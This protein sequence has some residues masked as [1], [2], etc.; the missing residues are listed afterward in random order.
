MIIQDRTGKG[1]LK[2]RGSEN[3]R[4]VLSI[5]GTHLFSNHW[6]RAIRLAR[7]L[8][9]QK[10]R[11]KPFTMC[12]ALLLVLLLVSPSAARQPATPVVPAAQSDNAV[13][14]PG[15]RPGDP[16]D[17]SGYIQVPYSTALNPS[18]GQITIE[19]WVKRSASDRNETIVGNGWQT[20]YWLGF[21][22]AGRLRFIPHGS[23]SIMDGN[24]VVQSDIWTHV[25]VTYD[26]TTRYY[27]INGVLDK[28][29][30]S[31]SGDLTPAPTGR[32]LGIGFDVDDTFTPN[33]FGGLIDNL[34]IWNVVRNA[35]AISDSMF[36]SFGTSQPGLLAEWSFDGDA[37]DPV[38]DHD[39]NLQGYVAFTNEGAIP[40]DI[41]VPQVSTTTS[42][43]ANCG[44]TEY[45]TATQVT[46]D[47]T[48]VWL[49]HIDSDLWVCFEA[50]YSVGMDTASV[51]LDVGHTRLDPAQPEHLM[52][53]VYD[54]GS[55]LAQEGTGTNTYTDTTRADGKWDGAFLQCCGEFPSRRAELR[56][57]AGLLGG[58]N[59]VIG[60]ALGKTTGL[61][62]DAHLWPALSIYNQPSTWSSSIL[63]E[64]RAYLP[65]M[66]RQT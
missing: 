41:R 55:T 17:L 8:F 49:M 44:A 26:G 4:T 59:H 65:L 36:L 22:S 57:S 27:Y 9:S 61:P 12:L 34:R 56:I 30:T 38:G 33:Y 5:V 39:G 45:T 50:P 7:D 35:T 18:G 15:V 28:T 32:S 62:L 20:S 1:W 3:R 58:W 66:L 23:D 2:R 54:D 48:A 21:S 63:G 43:D 51:Y 29:S 10:A 52:L 31:N 40:H 13:V 60:L 6:H 11:V 16:L 53:T 64:Y 19:A 14:L 24:I 46:V 37:S 42:L 25:A 47:G